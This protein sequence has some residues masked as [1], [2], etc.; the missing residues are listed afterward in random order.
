VTTGNMEMV[1][2]LPHETTNS[3]IVTQ[4]GRLF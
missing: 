4:Y 2:L 3:Q 1:G